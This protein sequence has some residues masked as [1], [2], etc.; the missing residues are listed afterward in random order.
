MS[1]DF[2]SYGNDSIR[3]FK[4]ADRVRK[5]PAIM[6]G[7]DT[8]DGYKHTFFEILTNSI[9]EFK[10]GFGKEVD[11]FYYKDHSIKIKDRGRGIPLDWNPVEERF[12]WDLI[13]CDMYAGGK[14]DDEHYS[15]NLGLNGLGACITQSTSEF[16][17][18]ESIRDGYR[19]SL[20]FEK[21][22]PV[23][24]LKKEKLTK[25]EAKNTGTTQ[26]WKGDLEVFTGIDIEP[27]YIR[28]ILKTQAIINSGIIFNFFLENDEGELD[29]EVFYYKDGIVE[30]IMEI[31]EGDLV[32][33][34]YLISGEGRGR[35]RADRDEYD[36]SFELAFAFTDN[37]PT[38]KVYHNSS[39]LEGGSPFKAIHSAFAYSFN[40][41][42][43]EFGLHKKNDP[44]ITYTDIEESIIVIN[45]SF[46]TGDK[47]SY[48]HQTKKVVNNK[49]I[50]DFMN[51]EIRK[52]LD[53]WFIENRDIGKKIVSHV[54]NYKRNKR[55]AQEHNK[56]LKKKIIKKIDNID[57]KVEKFVDC[58]SDDAE[59]RELFIVEGDSAAG[60]V[61]LARDAFFQGV[62]PVRGK[63]LN[64][65]KATK[66]SILKNQI[67]LDLINVLGCG[68]EG[69]NFDL[70]GLRWNKVILCTDADYDGYQIRTLILTMM[71]VLTPKLLTE[72]YV[73]IA[74]TPLFEISYKN[75]GKTETY[76]AY[77]DEELEEIIKGKNKS[78]LKIQRSKG[79]GQNNPD[80]MWNTTMNP[81]TRRLVRI[82]MNEDE[83]DIENCF[84]V[85]LG[86]N[87]GGRKEY[88]EN[89]LHAY[90]DEADV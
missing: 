10:A 66:T 8:V 43:K 57:N 46:S 52:A 73:Y 76:F 32:T 85:L 25:K 71:Y 24:D 59:I 47:T 15:G 11:V 78:N 27:D 83:E 12:N 77:S 18:V 49:F 62:M 5:R 19:Y 42:S 38:T 22:Y 68:I 58:E 16:F 56:I 6:L 88:I 87:L 4:G 80:M 65:L 13:Y 31:S 20:E 35:D 60:S 28:Q 2:E 67:I 44:R 72:G 45:N 64:C 86:K 53:V 23:G 3:A 36:T 9:D 75:K 17:T 84:D 21:G 54:L 34:P 7:S 50:R 37:K 70:D 41:H 33:E 55:K 81:E 61:K 14:M 89:N 48:E 74:E 69:K 79:L 30:Y 39:P 90:V 63:I 26:H 29:K 51:E 40:K 1:K 82:Q